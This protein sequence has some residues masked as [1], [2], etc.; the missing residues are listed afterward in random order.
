[1]DVR[2]ENE[3]G[4]L[5]HAGP[6]PDAKRPPDVIVACGVTYRFVRT[7][8]VWDKKVHVYQAASVRRPRTSW[9]VKHAAAPHADSADQ[10]APR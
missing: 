2:L 3:R 7:D 6:I 9:A 4:Q 10:R 8:G 5:A 1:L